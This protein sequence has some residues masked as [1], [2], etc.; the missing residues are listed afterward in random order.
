MSAT[1]TQPYPARARASFAPDTPGAQN[2]SFGMLGE[3]RGRF[4]IPDIAAFGQG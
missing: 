2:S 4:E 1:M 3:R